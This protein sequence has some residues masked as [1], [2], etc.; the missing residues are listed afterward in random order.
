MLK[1]DKNHGEKVEQSQGRKLLAVLGRVVRL[2][3]IEK[4]GSEQKLGGG[5]KV[6]QAG[7]WVR[8]LWA[9]RSARA[10]SLMQEVPG[11]V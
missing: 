8:V 1:V 6:S 3:L 10:D 4:V 11:L 5:K 2:T 7:T 9:Q